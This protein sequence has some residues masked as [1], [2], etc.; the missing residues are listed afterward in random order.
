MTRIEQ[1]EPMAADRVGVAVVL[2]RKRRRRGELDE[3]DHRMRRTHCQQAAVSA[4]RRAHGAVS[5][6]ERLALH[7]DQYSSAGGE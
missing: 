7:P 4:E 3:P 1:F 2:R 5:D 6:I